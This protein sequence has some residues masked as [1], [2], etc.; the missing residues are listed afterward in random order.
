MIYRKINIQ[1]I[2]SIY[3]VLMNN[4]IA[5][6]TSLI[7][8]PLLIPIY[9]LYIAFHSGTHIDYFPPR[10]Q[11]ITYLLIGLSTF[12]FPVSSLYMM[13]AFRFIPDMELINHKD[14][15]IPLALSS[16]SFIIAVILLLRLPFSV[17]E[18]IIYFLSISSIVIFIVL[19]V[20]RRYKISAHTTGI[21]S[22]LGTLIFIHFYYSV[23]ILVYFVILI[24]TSGLIG[25]ARL[26]LEAHE[27]SEIYSGFLLGIVSFLLGFF[28][29]MV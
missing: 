10:A 15:F 6:I 1:L 25:S 21:G 2:L 16:I 27:P 13:V 19:L 7:F 20:S 4:I 29:F 26:Q 5:R 14:R 11:Q 23:D 18:L 3:L 28:L 22:L 12:L 8:H 24:Y 9:F 17:P